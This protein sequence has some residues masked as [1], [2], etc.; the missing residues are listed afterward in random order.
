MAMTTKTR[1]PL[2]YRHQSTTGNRLPGWEDLHVELLAKDVEVTA[3]HLRSVL[4]KRREMSRWLMSQLVW[5]LGNWSVE[6]LE[7]ALNKA[8]VL[9]QA[10]RKKRTAA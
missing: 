5:A 3:G 1:I 6:R 10:R 7:R 4:T 9:D 8:R 2:R